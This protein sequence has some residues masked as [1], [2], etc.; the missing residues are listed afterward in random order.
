MRYAEM[1]TCSLTLYM[2]IYTH[3]H[4]HKYICT[5]S[6]AYVEKWKKKITLNLRML[7]VFC[8]SLNSFEINSPS[9]V[10]L[11]LFV[12]IDN[13]DETIKK[14]KKETNTD[15]LHMN[16]NNVLSINI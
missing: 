6:H 12:Q 9:H 8:E 16:K 4:I 1:N 10:C 5:N 2:S 7:R 15:E 13:E 3:I 11:F 14:K